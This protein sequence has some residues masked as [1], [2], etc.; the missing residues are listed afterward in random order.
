MNLRDL[1]WSCHICKKVRP[2][3]KISV[4][5]HPLIF[6]GRVLGSQNIRYCNDNPNCEKEAETYTF[7]E[8]NIE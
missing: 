8:H 2:D 3:N 1:T 6:K 5:T 7:V 4:K